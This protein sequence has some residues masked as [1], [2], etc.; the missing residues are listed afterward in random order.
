ML[1]PPYNSYF[2]FTFLP[3]YPLFKNNFSKDTKDFP[4]C[5]LSWGNF[6]KFWQS[7]AVQPLGLKI[8]N[9]KKKEF[10]I[11][12]FRKKIKERIFHI[13]FSKENKRNEET[14]YEGALPVSKSKCSSSFSIK[15]AFISW[16][17][18]EYHSVAL[19]LLLSGWDK[20]PL[21]SSFLLKFQC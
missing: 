3:F 5:L 21:M 17:T 2:T 8:I 14:S 19:N 4:F 15:D 13:L 10:F 18:T 7:C 11:F 1:P 6:P 9:D 12:F 20:F 16:Y